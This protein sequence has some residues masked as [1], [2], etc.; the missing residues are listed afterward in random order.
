[1]ARDFRPLAR[2][3]VMLLPL[4]MR[5]W[6][7][8][9]HF[10]WF[11]LA[12]LDELD[13]SGFEAGRRRG[14][15][16]RQGFDPR[17]LL[18]LLV[19]GYSQGQRSSRRIEELCATDVAYRVIC[20]QDPPDHTTIARFR[21]VH[22]EAVASLFVQVLELAGEAG[23]GRVGVIAVDGTRVGANA[24]WGKNRRRSWLREQVDE[25]M[26]EAERVDADEDVRFGPGESGSRVGDDWVEPASRTAK[27]RAA[28]ARADE[29]AGQQGKGR[30]ARAGAWQRRVERAEQEHAGQRAEAEQR[31]RDYQ[32]R[33]AAAE[34]YGSAKPPGRPAPPADEA[35]PTRRAAAR[36]RWAR[37]RRDEAA[38]KDA[39][40]RQAR[41]PVANLTDPESGWMPTG[42]GWIQG[43]NAQL[44]VS[45][46]QLVLGV[47]VTN[48]TVDVDQFEPMLKLAERG[49]EALNRGRARKG[50]GSER[51]G[52]VLADAGYFSRHNL[53]AAGPDRLI[54]PAGRR[55][56]DEAARSAPSAEYAAG[57]VAP[58]DP[59]AAMKARM[60]DPAQVAI[61]RR[62]GVIVEPVNGHLKDR[63]GLRQYARRGNAACQ[64]ET[65]L[66]TITANL[67]KIYR[68]GS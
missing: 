1:M 18:G 37:E 53:T 39:A 49:V 7:P 16:G 34:R 62:R 36:V 19:Y 22:D 58:E 51:I 11:L 52:R 67:L 40:E 41:D 9:E 54:A 29:V 30:Q 35:A 64:A 59:V 13:L 65:E 20:A 3:Q 56:L 47:Q 68:H 23:L 31:H 43:Y 66:A 10:V 42:K 26:A 27:I 55:R 8:P 38:A 63:H 61:Y 24:S 33:R 14:G 25:A 32:Q 6:L 28:L 12:V 48:A 15:V 57:D 50:T 60:R 21:Q 2:D 4:D 44:A 17:M 45:E 46:D 5:E